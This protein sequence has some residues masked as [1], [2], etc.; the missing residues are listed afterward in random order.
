MRCGGFHTGVRDSALD[1]SLRLGM[2]GIFKRDR[3]KGASL[4]EFAFLAPLLVLLLLGTV[5]FG[6]G[7]AQQIDVRHKGREALRMAIVDDPV[8]EVEARICNNSIVKNSQIVHLTRGSGPADEGDP[9]TVTIE[10]DVQQL[11]GF[12]GWL[13]GPNPTITTTVEGRV[14]QE[15]TN[16][17]PGVD[18]IDD[19]GLCT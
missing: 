10:T 17:M 15:P 1:L 8:S 14:E 4:V 12:F 9:V 16:W 3:E 19:L 11:T 2:L 6:W 7:L 18:F 13:Y 5:E